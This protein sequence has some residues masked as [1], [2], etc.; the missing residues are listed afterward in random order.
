MKSDLRIVPGPVDVRDQC[1]ANG[2]LRLWLT[3]PHST[4]GTLDK[5]PVKK[6]SRSLIPLKQAIKAAA[7]HPFEWKTDRII[8]RS[9]CF[10]PEFIAFQGHFSGNPLL[11]AF[12]PIQLAQVMLEAAWQSPL[13]LA[14]IDKAKFREPLRPGPT[15]N[16]PCQLDETPDRMQATVT[17]TVADRPA[18]TY[19]MAV[20]TTE[21]PSE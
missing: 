9:F 13:Q 5:T 20:R 10:P 19:Q 8:V 14:R 11:S 15:V 2:E 4:P 3:P 12:V 17:L 18:A 6:T 1:L 21:R 7:G 16:L